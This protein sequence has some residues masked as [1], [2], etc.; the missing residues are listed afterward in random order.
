MKKTY[1]LSICLFTIVPII[2]LWSKEKDTHYNKTT[3]TDSSHITVLDINNFVT[4]IRNDGFFTKDNIFYYCEENGLFPKEWIDTWD[5]PA[6][7]YT[8]GFIWGGRINEGHNSR[9]KVGG[10]AYHCGLTPGAILGIRTGLSEN[11]NTADL[12]VWRVRRDWQLADFT[13]ESKESQNLLPEEIRAQ[14]AYDWQ[15]WPAERGAP[16]EDINDNG[17]YEPEIDIPGIPGA[18]QTLWLVAND[19]DRLYTLN[20]Y[21]SEPLGLEVQTT[22]WAYQRP[23]GDPFGDITFR[24]LR[25]IYKG[26]AQ[27]ENDA[28]IKDMYLSQWSDPDVVYQ[29]DYAGTDS[30]LGLAYAYD[31]GHNRHGMSVGYIQLQGP[32]IPEPDSTAIFN[33]ENKSGYQNLPVTSTLILSGHDSA[34][35][36]DPPE[37]IYT[38]SVEWYNLL[39][40][41]RPVG[42]PW[43][44][45]ETSQTTRYPYSGDPSEGTG[46]VDID[47]DGNME[48]RRIGINSGPFTLAL[49]DTQEIITAVIGD[50]FS[51]SKRGEIPGR[52]VNFLKSKAKAIQSFLWDKVAIHLSTDSIKEN[53][54]VRVG[55]EISLSARTLLFDKNDSIIDLVWSIT[56]RPN[57]SSAEMHSLSGELNAFTPDHEGVYRI[58]VSI[59]TSLGYIASHFIE[60]AATANQPPEI[61]LNLSSRNITFGDSIL[62]DASQTK[63]PEQNNLEYYFDA[64]GITGIQNPSN[65]RR[66]MKPISA[67]YIPVNLTIDDGYFQYVSSDTV[68]VKPKLENIK[69]RYTYQ[70]TA[71]LENSRLQYLQYFFCGDTLL[72]CNQETGNGGVF[73][74]KIKSGAILPEAELEIEGAYKILKI[75]N[76]FL[77]L[78]MQDSENRLPGTLAVYSIGQNWHLEPVLE[79]YIPDEKQI[80]HS[81]FID[82]ELYINNWGSGQYKID[83]IPNPAEPVIE[84][85]NADGPR[86]KYKINEDYLY[87][88]Q[89]YEHYAADRNTLQAVK[90]INLP[91]Q[92]IHY[93]RDI[94][95]G[96]MFFTIR[97]DHYEYTSLVIYDITDIS[98]PITLSSIE[99]DKSREENWW[100]LPNA[101]TSADYLN[102]NILAIYPNGGIIFYNISDPTQPRRVGAFYAGITGSSSGDVKISEVN[103]N[104]YI[105]GRRTYW[106]SSPYTGISSVD[107]GFTF[108]DNIY[109]IG[110]GYQ[111]FQNYPNPFNSTTR[112]S[113]YLPESENVKIDVYNILGQ[114]V[115]TV[116]NQSMTKGAH[117]IYFIPKLYASGLYFYRI[118]AGNFTA[119]K[120]MIYLR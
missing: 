23:L 20:L 52:S 103:N 114:H 48:D 109:Q 26:T 90:K 47:P 120:K 22:L 104:Y 33:F 2:S 106:K 40:G 97:D 81:F 37:G 64:N 53:K 14:Y 75:K 28:I 25:I 116:L 115:E 62:L 68:F 82:D 29:W 44:N 84:A 112:I 67:G 92:Q 13:D 100:W 78:Q 66:W 71:L 18:D 5:W 110:Q 34:P 43:V 59:V 21:G 16:F 105:H 108:R 99:L 77:F 56:G 117:E 9:I 27:T 72:V 41:L 57:G 61:V 51:L 79:K 107:L 101:I 3:A 6:I 46:W 12:H 102:D 87:A 98:N 76:K 96:L 38:G 111:L 91:D 93:L 49:G 89:N 11:H 118:E 119:V 60:I 10:T 55:Q 39:R 50:N 65:P 58:Q 94:S 83:I 69:I 8:E 42:L 85:Y 4:K 24:R 70:D 7:V 63:D 45:P 31:F 54:F 17:Q 88:T 30:V 36:R 74:Y 1:L 73:A 35:N 15:H 19:L 113:F 32:I 95:D 80:W 86:I